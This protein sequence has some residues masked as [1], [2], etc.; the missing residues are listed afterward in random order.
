MLDVKRGLGSQVAVIDEER[1][2]RQSKEQRE[3]QG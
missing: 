2:P 1:H 3:A